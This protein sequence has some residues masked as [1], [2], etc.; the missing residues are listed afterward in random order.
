MKSSNTHKKQK[1]QFSRKSSDKWLIGVTSIWSAIW[2]VYSAGERGWIQQIDCFFG[3]FILLTSLILV[4]GLFVAWPLGLFRRKISYGILVSSLIIV[5]SFS[6]SHLMPRNSLPPTQ[7]CLIPGTNGIVR[8][9]SYESRGGA[10]VSD[11]YGVTYE[12][13]ETPETS[14]FYSY[15]SPGISAIECRNDA[16]LLKDRFRSPYVL[17]IQWI[18]DD[19]VHEPLRFYKGA[20][21][22]VKYGNA[23]EGWEGVYVPTPT[24]IK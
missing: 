2:I 17:S 13:N 7:T 14:I 20:L 1:F 22:N 10:T 9:Y 19:L 21:R 12:D 23:I 8:F 3:F 18:H 6:F 16:V 11:G 5:V 4:F 24:P 15:S